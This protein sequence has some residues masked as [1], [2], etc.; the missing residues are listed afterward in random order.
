[1]KK[2][3]TN[4]ELFINNIAKKYSKSRNISMLYFCKHRDDSII[5]M[6]FAKSLEKNLDA[7]SKVYA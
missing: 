2:R 4:I 1:M 7:P 6:F 3:V 5:S